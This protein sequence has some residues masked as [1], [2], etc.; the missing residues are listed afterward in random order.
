[1]TREEEMHIVRRVL[2]GDSNA[3]EALVTE[4]ER[5]VYNLALKMLGNEADAMD[6]SQETF[7]KAYT[8]LAGFRGE[9]KFSVWLYRLASN[10]CVDML[11]A[12]RGDTVSLS[13]EEDGGSGGVQA[14]I[15]DARFSPEK[16]LER[17]E[18]RRAVRE[19][20]AALPEDY[21]RVLVLR[22]LGGLSYEQIADTLDV[23]MGTVKSRIFRA[24][25]KLCKI[26][27]SDGNFFGENPSEQT[28]G[29]AQ[30]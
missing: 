19:G 23:D 13:P 16:L 4:N 15:P 17:K 18:L 9:S 3:F 21:R 28:K 24:R 29:G 22:E 14:D 8:S 7:V 30:A 11:R 25:K 10:V 27:S 1:M 12:R 6:A 2:S 26:L 20:L 5:L